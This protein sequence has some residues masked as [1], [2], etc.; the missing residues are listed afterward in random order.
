MTISVHTATAVNEE[1]HTDDTDAASPKSFEL[2]GKTYTFHT[3]MIDLYGVLQICNS[4]S[5]W[6]ASVK[7][8]RVQNFLTEKLREIQS[9]SEGSPGENFFFIGLHKAKNPSSGEIRWT[10]P[11]GSLLRNQSD[12]PNWLSDGSGK[13]SGGIEINCVAMSGEQ[14]SHSHNHRD[15]AGGVA[16][17]GDEFGKWV[18]RDC[19]KKNRFIC[20]HG[21]GEEFEFGNF[22]FFN[23]YFISECEGFTLIDDNLHLNC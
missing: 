16:G 3:E 19:E 1:E 15:G 21:S 5:G 12:N 7:T 22:V 9:A 14:I 10:W 23:D 6:L 13:I 2:D 17:G 11:D 20:E 4:S 18:P 8:E